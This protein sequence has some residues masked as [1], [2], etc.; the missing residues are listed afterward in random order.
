MRISC[1]KSDL[2]NSVN[3]VMKAVPA[4]STMPILECLIIEASSLGIKLI[5]NDM[6]IG[7]ETL[8]KGKMMEVGAVA[9]NAK[10]FSEII[11]RLPDNEVNIFT[12]DNYVTEI[13]CEKSKFSI[14]GR[15]GEEFPKLPNIIK[16]NPLTLSQF[17]L[18]EV[19]RQTVFSISDNESNKIM[20]GELFDIK[21]NELRVISL[22][23]HR[24]S[25]RKIFMKEE[26][27]DRKVII[28]G[29]TLNEISKI[30]SGESSSVVDIY[31][32][33]KHALFEF[34]DTVVVTRLIEG[35]YYRIDQMLSSD[36]ETKVSINKKELLSCIE[37]AS[38]LIRETDRKPIIIKISENNFEL[39][40]E[41]SLGSMKEEIDITMEGKDI[42]IGFNPKF[43]TDA[44]RVIDDETVDI[45]LI[46]PKAP[47]F[48]RDKE[49][50][51]IYL[52]LPVNIHVRAD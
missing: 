15:S 13:I 32:S 3:I 5:A 52:I 28:P 14:V 36:Y 6:E 47:C 22:D 18:K 31:F 17:T 21:K 41:T 40:V 16:E 48:I 49:Q 50:S 33:E 7:I 35:E 51:Y 42:V 38:L 43:L 29:K 37:R 8:V 19:I 9:L 46:N 2:L 39:S 4:K 30:L 20:T 23:G 27:D 24:I 26:Y 44:L 25:I 1:Q 45:Y 34:D 12:E 11:R 10:V